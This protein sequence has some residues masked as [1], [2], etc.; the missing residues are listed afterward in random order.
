VARAPD[1]LTARPFA[2]RGL[3]DAAAGVIENTTSAFRA[4]L[5]GGYAIECDVQLSRDGEAVVH[6]DERLGR[7]TEGDA[8]L[9]TLTA[10]ELAQ[11]RFRGTGDRIGTLGELLA[12]VGGHA[13]ILVEIK[14]RFDGDLRLTRR[15]VE[16]LAGYRGPVAAMS[17]DPGV[18]ETL[19]AEVPALTR[20]IVAERRYD[21]A[22]WAGLG[23]TRKRSMGLLLHAPR[24]R[25][26]FVAWWVKDLPSP[27]PLIARMLCGLPLLTWTVRT[28]ADR[29]TASRWADQ[30]IFEGLRP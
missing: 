11:V 8:A 17:F 15:V 22:E 5:A 23:P 19:R 30:I 13:G 14:S 26:D 3:H 24:T 4:A 10:A 29:A 12:L 7:L 6:H 16:V 2:H 28:E 9:E 27:A 25:P 21:H 18:V 1:W 20:G